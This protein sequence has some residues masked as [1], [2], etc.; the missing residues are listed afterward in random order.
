M[1]SSTVTLL[2]A[3][4]CKQAISLAC[5]ARLR[6]GSAEPALL[7]IRSRSCESENPKR[8]DCHHDLGESA[9]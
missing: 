4:A 5:F 7:L 9:A 1:E 3:A 8:F 6:K 2:V